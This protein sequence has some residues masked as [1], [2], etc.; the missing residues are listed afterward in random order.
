MSSLSSRSF[1]WRLDWRLLIWLAAALVPLVTAALLWPIHRPE[2][3]G[4]VSKVVALLSTLGIIG[5]GQT[6]LT[7]HYAPVKHGDS[8]SVTAQLTRLELLPQTV[9]PGNGMQGL[10]GNVSIENSGDVRLVFLGG[11]YLVTGYNATATGGNRGNVVD[12]A[13]E[14]A[15]HGRSPLGG[16]GTYEA[17]PPDSKESKPSI[18]KAGIF[19]DPG[20]VRRFRY[21]GRRKSRPAETSVERKGWF[22]TGSG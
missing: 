4:P 7:S 11:M 2:S 17:Y 22:R 15:D 16:V 6:L 14:V 19:F 13:K 3:F 1:D 18:V 20:A 10:R 12:I 5:A 9:A 8:L 21:S